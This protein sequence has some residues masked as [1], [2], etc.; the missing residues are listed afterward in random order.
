MTPVGESD[1]ATAGPQVN[2]EEGAR[3][4]HPASASQVAQ[5]SPV[6]VTTGKA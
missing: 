4:A 3:W 2:V 5:R 6:T 1:L